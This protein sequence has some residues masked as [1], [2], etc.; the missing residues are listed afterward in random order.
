MLERNFFE[1]ENFVS[2]DEYNFNTYSNELVKQFQTICSEI[3]VQCKL[4]CDFI[5]NPVSRS[6]IFCYAE[7]L[8]P[9]WEG[10]VDA[11][12]ELR[13]NHNFKLAPWKEWTTT[14]SPSWWSSYNKV[15]HARLT[16]DN[17]K[18]ANL[19]NTFNA[20]AALYILE[21]YFYKEIVERENPPLDPFKR[22]ANSNYYFTFL[23]WDE[24]VTMAYNLLLEH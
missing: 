17:E 16:N 3:D 18:E 4:I 7:R 14:T 20:L 22:P 21:T 6:N 10:F 5:G 13:D 12:I 11:E 9:R 2:F 23:G 15:K 8:I 19:G 24:N 1:Y